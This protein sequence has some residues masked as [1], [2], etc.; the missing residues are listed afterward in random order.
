[1]EDK[2]HIQGEIS[3]DPFGVIVLDKAK[4]MTSHDVVDRVRRHFG[5]KKVGHGGTLDPNATGVLVLMIGKATRMSGTFINQD[6][7]YL[8]MVKLGVRTDSGDC[9]G[10]ILDSKKVDVPADKVREV[11][12]SFVG[13]I[14]QVPPMFSAKKVGGK[15]LYEFARKGITVEREPKKVHIKDLE[16]LEMGIPFISLRI[17]CSSGTYI[18]QLVDDV[19]EKLG[20]G[21]VLT[22]LRRTRSGDFDISKAVTLE[23]LLKMDQKSFL[24]LVKTWVWRFNQPFDHPGP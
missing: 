7:E 5:I 12:K 17:L 21:A 1:M 8:A 15:K 10:K 4:G 24:D 19:G 22:E 13:E 16:V 3:S 18:R 20:C 11:L 2:K 9:D 6:K 14:D 23:S